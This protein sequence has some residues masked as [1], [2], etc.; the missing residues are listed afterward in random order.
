MPFMFLCQKRHLFFLNNPTTLRLK[1]TLTILSFLFLSLYWSFFAVKNLA[2]SV[3]LNTRIDDLVELSKWI[4]ENTLADSA[5]ILPTV[6]FNEVEKRHL[7]N[8]PFPD[9]GFTDFSVFQSFS[10]RRV[11]V[12][13]KRGAA[14]MWCPEYFFEWKPRVDSILRYTSLNDLVY[15]ARIEKI[16]YIIYDLT[17][18]PDFP[19]FYKTRYF[20]LIKVF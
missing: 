15:F 19:T 16:P 13:F 7:R 14:V 1:K 2:R 8:Q 18:Y 4:K 12:D 10:Q 5:F 20:G 6:N 17:L 11:F 9:Y 3:R